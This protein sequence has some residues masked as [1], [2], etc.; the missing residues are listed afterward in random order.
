MVSTAVP[1]PAV[2]PAAAASARGAWAARDAGPPLGTLRLRRRRTRS[3]QA[4][5]SAGSASGRQTANG[6][7]LL[8]RWKGVSSLL[9]RDGLGPC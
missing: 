8:G 7:R 3:R 1:H 5:A 4:R 6:Y 2:P 9:W